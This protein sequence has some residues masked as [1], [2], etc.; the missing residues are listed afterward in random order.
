M[1]NY[2]FFVKLY[3]FSNINNTVASTTLNHGIY[4]K[5]KIELG[6][7]ESKSHK[8]KNPDAS[9]RISSYSSILYFLKKESQ[10]QRKLTIT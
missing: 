2:L 10:S 3:H 8:T 7:W 9:V 4:S 1:N 5:D 6:G